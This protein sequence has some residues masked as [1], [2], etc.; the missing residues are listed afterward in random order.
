M[1]K[2]A[3]LNTI[4]KT[5]VSF[6]KLKAIAATTAKNLNKNCIK[7]VMAKRDLSKIKIK[8]LYEAE[9]RFEVYC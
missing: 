8:Q 9:V 7:N 1:L 2:V 3:L 4:Y 5:I 6:K